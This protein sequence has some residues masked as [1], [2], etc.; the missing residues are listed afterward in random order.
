MTTKVATAVTHISRTCRPTCRPRALCQTGPSLAGGC[1]IPG[2]SCENIPDSVLALPAERCLR[3]TR[4]RSG[5]LQTKRMVK[6]ARKKPASGTL[7]P[8]L[9]ASPLHSRI[10]QGCKIAASV[11]NV[12][13]VIPVRPTKNEELDTLSKDAAHKEHECPGL[14]GPDRPIYVQPRVCS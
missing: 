7:R 8:Q 4:E 12:P 2:C 11:Q 10:K 13:E 1:S 3:P 14:V 9:Q 6:P 5:D